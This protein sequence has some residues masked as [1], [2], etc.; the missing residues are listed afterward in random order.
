MCHEQAAIDNLKLS[1]RLR[2]S[3]AEG[4]TEEEDSGGAAPASPSSSGPQD[5]RSDPLEFV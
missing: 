2:Q 5:V 3:V 4:A 1:R